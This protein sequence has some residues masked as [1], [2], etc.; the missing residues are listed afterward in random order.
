MQAITEVAQEVLPGDTLKTSQ[1][2][3]TRRP[4]LPLLVPLVV[5]AAMV[6]ILCT[7]DS[8]I[9]IRSFSRVA[10]SI[11]I[12]SLSPFAV[13]LDW[14]YSMACLALLCVECRVT[15]CGACAILAVIDECME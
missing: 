13:V 4:P 12:N 5:A 15:F 11:R 14:G 3:D 7:L 10:M 9:G 6:T 8:H 2:L 1:M